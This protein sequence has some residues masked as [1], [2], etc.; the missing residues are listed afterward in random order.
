[1]FNPLLSIALVIFLL[2]LGYKFSS[3]FLRH[4]GTAPTEINFADRVKAAT[5]STLR[6]VFSPKIVTL[7]KALLLDVLLQIRVYR[8]DRWR[9]LAHMLL[10]Y[11]FILLL[12][13]HALQSIITANLF[14]DYYP[15]VNPFF[16]L[17][18][19]FG[20]MVLAGVA[21]IVVRRYIST[22]RRL[23]TNSRDH[24]AIALVAAILVS[25]FMLEGLKITSY[26]EF[27]RMVED[28][29]GLDDEDEIA[30]LKA[31]WIKEYGLAAAH[32]PGEL[33]DADMEAAREVHELNCA[34]CHAPA[35]NAFASYGVAKLIKP[36]AIWLDQAGAVNFIWHLHF[37]FCFAALAWLPFSKMFHLIATPISLIVNR[38]M[39]VDKA[40]PANI[41]TRQMVE[42]DACT[43]CGS[44]S[45]NCSAAMMY[46]ARGNEFILPSEK[47]ATL[48][49]LASGKK[50]DTAQM[51]S[52]QEGVFIC[53]NCD[54]CTVR[55]P[56]GI[57]LKEIW[58]GV[59]EQL[60][61]D[62][63]PPP[64]MLSP[65]SFARGLITR[66]RVAS[67]AYRKP[68]DQAYKLVGAGDGVVSDADE[69]I[70]LNPDPG[71]P[72]RPVADTSSFRHCFSCQTCTT[73]C[74]V[75]GNYE[76]AEKRLGLLP[77]QIMCSLGLG[78]NDMAAGARM[79][80]DCLTCYQC[81]ESCPQQVDICDL[82]FELKNRAAQANGNS[83]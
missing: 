6:T 45:L 21:L 79:I 32:E 42:L 30:V 8:E 59:R 58:Y 9:W 71:Q 83:R 28:Y 65:L 27:E 35:G 4:I 5:A 75:V 10:F 60:L 16:F 78:L 69:P 18:D 52:L 73:V 55:C 61:D 26:G 40:D 81:Q 39:D 24:V 19:L 29:A 50:L 14:S 33:E 15:T 63:P 1:M 48:R 25:G 13:M 11:G 20:V 66:D 2:G 17:R 82:L 76:D 44:C 36:V 49:R 34:E 7:F 46:E 56:S 80:W 38:V 57:R 22:P 72:V 51:R 77:H 23:R 53:T 12:L 3:W 43:H 74:P 62:T 37:I 31:L 67:G 64:A 70:V 41:L 54:R 68:L 47:M